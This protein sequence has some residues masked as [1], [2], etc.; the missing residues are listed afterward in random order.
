[1]IG[2]VNETLKCRQH[3]DCCLQLEPQSTSLIKELL[4]PGGKV[5]AGA[6]RGVHA[7]LPGQGKATSANACLSSFA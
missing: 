5:I 2:V 6:F 3:P 7:V 1:M 4:H